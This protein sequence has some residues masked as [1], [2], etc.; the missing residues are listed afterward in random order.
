MGV[1]GGPGLQRLVDALIVER[2]RPLPAAVVPAR[3]VHESDRVK[4]ERRRLLNE[5]MN[6]R[7]D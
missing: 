1:E 6:T 4:A 7:A 5:A 3:E 2:Y